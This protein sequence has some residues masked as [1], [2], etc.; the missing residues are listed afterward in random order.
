MS[1]FKDRM[2]PIKK[3]RASFYINNTIKDGIT[4]IHEVKMSYQY[5]QGKYS[6][7]Y[8]LTIKSFNANDYEAY[9]GLAYEAAKDYLNNLLNGEL[10]FIRIMF[11]QVKIRLKIL[12]TA[13]MI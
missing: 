8:W 2:R 11:Y 12:L 13:F 10:S 3:F 1:E 5:S 4:A 6:M 7:A 9:S